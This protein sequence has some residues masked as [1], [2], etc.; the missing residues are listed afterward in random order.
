MIYKGLAAL[1]KGGKGGQ[2]TGARR[3]GRQ[4]EEGWRRDKGLEQGGGGA[5]CLG[6][7]EFRCGTV[8]IWVTLARAGLIDWTDQGPR[9]TCVPLQLFSP[10]P[11]SPPLPQLWVQLAAY[12]G[13][14]DVV[15]VEAGGCCLL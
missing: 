5:D 14:G 11:V 12:W 10:D 7:Q 1:R 13:G 9:T 15:A 3:R 6:G 2:R 4:E 8:R